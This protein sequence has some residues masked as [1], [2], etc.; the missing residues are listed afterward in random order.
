MNYIVTKPIKSKG[1]AAILV[2][3]FG[4]LGLFYSSILGG[5]MMGIIA[6]ILIWIFFLYGLVSGAISIVAI[7]IVF[8]CLYYIICLIWALNAVSTYNK[9]IIASAGYF[10]QEYRGD[11]D[12]VKR[13]SNR[14]L[15]LLS[16]LLIA[17]LI[18]I[19]FYKDSKNGEFQQ[20]DRQ[21][22]TSLPVSEKNNPN[23]KKKKDPTINKDIKDKYKISKKFFEDLDMN[24]W[25]TTSYFIQV[26]GRKE[27]ESINEE[28][29]RYFIN[30]DNK[31]YMIIDGEVVKV[32][33]YKNSHNEDE[34]FIINTT[35]GDEFAEEFETIEITDKK[36]KKIHYECETVK[37]RDLKINKAYLK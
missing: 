5:V 27:S 18:I 20:L 32:W 28:G 26:P 13:K 31:I 11:Y 25:K 33:H 12:D 23:S 29:E 7:V 9:K 3:L 10:N 1:I 22:Q 16:V 19:L 37:L 24:I 8:C 17:S 6:P 30:D 14:W 2:M 34:L 36:G 4:G 35:E 15:W 21:S